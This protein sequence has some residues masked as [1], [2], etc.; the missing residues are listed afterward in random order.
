MLLRVLIVEDSGDDTQLMIREIQRGGYE[1]EQFH[2]GVGGIEKERSG[3]SLPHNLRLD[4]RR[5]C[6]CCFESWR[7]RFYDQGKS[8]AA[9]TGH[10]ARIEGGRD[11][12]R[13]EESV[14]SAQGHPGAPVGHP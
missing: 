9:Y 13:T 12:A 1:V 3:S 6:S 2:A 5:R 11:P 14:R 7:T 10:P 8:G 4:R